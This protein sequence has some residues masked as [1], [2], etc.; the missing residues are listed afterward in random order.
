MY[1][2]LTSQFHFSRFLF[3]LKQICPRK[4]A[5]SKNVPLYGILQIQYFYQRT[6]LLVSGY[7]PCD[8]IRC[9]AGARCVSSNASCVCKSLDECPQDKGHTV[10]GSDGR[11]YPSRCHLQVTACKNQTSVIYKHKG[12]CPGREFYLRGVVAI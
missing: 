6:L 3:S 11:T 12:K 8:N 10:C 4:F 9:S 5:P 1:A 2:I 7:N